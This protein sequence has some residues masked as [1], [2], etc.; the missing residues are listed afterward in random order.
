MVRA[1]WSQVIQTFGFP[2]RFHSDQG[3]NIDSDLMKQFCD[4]YGV[5]K[6]RTTPYHPAGNGRVERMN[7]TLLV[8]LRTLEAEKQSSRPKLLN[9]RNSLR[10]CTGPLPQ[11]S[12]ATPQSSRDGR[13]E[14]P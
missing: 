13:A 2:S 6:R 4:L 8:M 14:M 11:Q 12:P 10:L 1:I 9:R 3:P 5:A 7:Q